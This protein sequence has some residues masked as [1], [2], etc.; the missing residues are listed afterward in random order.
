MQLN[1]YWP[2]NA[3]K[4]KTALK[5]L[6]K[7]LLIMNFTT[8]FLLAFCLTASAGGYSQGIT[9]NVKDAPLEDVFQEIKKQTG[10]TFVY[11]KD[12][13]T[14]SK[15]VTLQLK[16]ATIQEALRIC[17]AEQPF[18]YNVINSVVVVNTKA[19][20]TINMNEVPEYIAR[21]PI[22][23]KGHVIDSSGAPIAGA[24][25]QVKGDKKKG[26]NS[27]ANGYFELNGVDENA[28]LV[29]SGINIETYEVKLNGRKDLTTIMIR[30]KTKA[31]N[32]VTIVSTGY[33]EIPK[34]RV[35][36]S[37]TVIDNK[38]LNEQVGT[39]ILNRL[40]GVSSGV[41]FEKNKSN[42]RPNSNL[43]IA[44]RGLSTI[45]GPLDPLIVLD[46]F[47]YEGNID[48]INPNDVENITILKDAAATSIWGARAGNGVIVITTKKGK[49]NQ[50]LQIGFNA[51]TIFTQKPDLYSIPQI[52]PAEY[53]DF[54]QFL[55]NQG[56]FDSRIGVGWIGLTP[57]VQV[58]SDARRGLINSSDSA[59]LINQLKSTDSRDQYLKY[60]YTA[61]IT[62]QYAVNL[63]GGS[64]NNAFTLSFGYDNAKGQLYDDLKKL[65]VRV[66]NIYRPVKNLDV[67]IGAYYTNSQSK[68]GRRN[69]YNSILINGR[70]VPYLRFADDAGN[71]LS[72]PT[73][74]NDSYTDTVG[75]GQLLNWKYYP[76]EDY[77]YN[78]TALT[79]KE[80]FT[81]V[82][83]KYTIKPY[84]N[85]EGRYQYQNQTTEDET[86]RELQ[87]FGT[88]NI[89]N[90]FTQLN[91]SNGTV[92][93][94]PIG[95]IRTLNFG[96]VNSHTFRGQLNFNQTWGSHEIAALTGAEIREAKTKA[97]NSILYGYNDD[98]RSSRNV[99][100]AT[101]YPTFVTGDFEQIEGDFS[102][103][104]LTYR[105][106]STYMNA[107][108]TYDRKYVLTASARRD[109]SNIFGLNTNDKWKPL[110]SLG[111]GWNISNENFY[112][113]TLIPT[114]KLRLTYGFNGNVDLARSAVAV[115]RFF[116]NA[117]I[118]NYPFARIQI[119]NNPEL[120]WEKT[121]M[122]N[123]GVDFSV[124]KGILNGSIEYYHKRGSDLY[125]EGPIDYTA[126]GRN[127]MIFNVAGM[128]GNG[129]DVILN[130]KIVDRL[131]KWNSNL[132]FNYNSNKTTDYY[133]NSINPLALKIGAGRTI[134]PVVGKPLYAVS[135]FRW[136]G[137]D[138]AGNPQ[139]FVKGVKSINYSDI[140]LNGDIVYIGSTSPTFFGSFIN[141]FSWK[142]V[143]IS[144]N[145]AYKLNYYFQKPSISYS[146][147]IAVGAGH[148]DY[149]LR[150]QN[151]GD[152][153]RTNVP[154]F[155]YPSDESRDNFYLN[156]ELNVL[157]GDHIRLQYVNVVYT[158]GNQ[159]KKKFPFKDIQLYINASNL[160]ILW[161]AN[162]QKLDPD[163]PSDIRPSTTFAFG[164]R[165]NL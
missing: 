26:T 109:G 154:S 80:L 91:G 162:N 38:T 71:S 12:L 163:Y 18:T 13:T 134:S 150:W 21:P 132:L 100:F 83:L 115:G 57:A 117:P 40:D 147:L 31:M 106:V 11:T 143:T 39:N 128:K 151:P 23:V 14:K 44:I 50:K 105:F 98:P 118:T 55:F 37:F 110:W 145:I 69:A 108:Y 112:K 1:A 122:L 34:E 33:Q 17:F 156:S 101:F 136:A 99:N 62:Q 104:E 155:Q 30:P 146:S 103:N 148:S 20:T 65:N 82:G 107:S 72:V 77:K 123:I 124:S 137:L 149:A 126:T 79:T 144:M 64:N 102:S 160:G 114:L 29:I 125:G 157:K 6:T 59:T 95:G 113:S 121:R 63:R 165:G 75:G 74:F 67:S 25:I 53:I 41:L 56:F 46:G 90:L 84:L 120:R 164:L 42:N 86:I 5:G 45:N 8:T 61:P 43:N 22:D 51:N 4:K 58:F 76:L 158:I 66:E 52:S 24:S 3:T 48:N 135:A 96:Q 81:T 15:K 131:F 73:V 87:S 127:I 68:S 140:F 119:L 35:T 88:R 138:S 116:S 85:I 54:E 133:T 78:K 49:F 10:Y 32:E 130:S 93:N 2:F 142:N 153:L 7:T 19:K 60:F 70:Q 94:V 47:I 16:N 129:V 141:S 27:D 159:K 89:I 97:N 92:Y 152:E 139:G 9:L 111:A 36:G 161:R 28:T